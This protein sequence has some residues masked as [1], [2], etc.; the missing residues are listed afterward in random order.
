MVEIIPKEIPKTPKWINGL[1][2]FSVAFLLLSV[3]GYFLLNSFIKNGEDNLAS[4]ESALA[5]IRT[6]DKVALEREVSKY[7][8]K[9][10]DFSMIAEQHLEPSRIFSLIEDNSHPRVWFS[11][12]NFNPRNGEVKLTGEADNFTTLGQQLLIFKDEEAIYEINLEKVSINKEGK[13]D[14]SLAFY[15]ISAIQN[16]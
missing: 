14:F 2:Y 3:V 16:E 12:F 6:A 13:I 7:Q 8:Y 4:I 15:L 5:K 1:F 11:N 10:N 9:V